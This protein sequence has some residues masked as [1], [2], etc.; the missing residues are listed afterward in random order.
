M[1]VSCV[2]SLKSVRRL[3]ASPATAEWMGRIRAAILTLADSA[4]LD[5]SRIA[6]AGY[7]FGGASALEY[8]RTQRR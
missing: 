6:L 3:A 1:V 2:K 7:C 5:V 4:D 8:L